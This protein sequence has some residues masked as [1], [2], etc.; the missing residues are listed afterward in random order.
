[1]IVG[2][3]CHSSFRSC[4]QLV[5]SVQF[6]FSS[7]TKC[8]Q[9]WHFWNVYIWK[10]S[11]NVNCLYQSTK[12]NI[13]LHCNW[14]GSL[15]PIKFHLK[16]AEIALPSLFITGKLDSQWRFS[17]ITSNTKL[18]FLSTTSFLYYFY[19]SF[20]SS[21]EKTIYVLINYFTLK[22]WFFTKDT[23]VT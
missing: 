10:I 23:Y 16:L 9:C 6:E 4:S 21:V 7:N 14:F 2:Y 19:Q 3:I 11:L 13:N 18:P 17:Q 22:H 15:F 8:W 1:M 5:A 12:T 20:I